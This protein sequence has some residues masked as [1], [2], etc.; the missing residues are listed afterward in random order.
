MPTRHFH[1]FVFDESDIH[2]DSIVLEIRDFEDQYREYTVPLLY[3]CRKCE[4]AA[5]MFEEVTKYQEEAHQVRGMEK[6]SSYFFQVQRTRLVSLEPIN[7]GRKWKTF[8]KIVEAY[9]LGEVGDCSFLSDYLNENG[10]D[11]LEA[12]H[13]EK[14]KSG[15]GKLKLP[16]NEKFVAE[17]INSYNQL[18][19]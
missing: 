13:G 5:E 2:A 8:R 12:A 3:L 11:M 14:E 4:D 10:P 18:A 17:L 1:Y 16:G 9:N 6:F 7:T 15:I 19:L